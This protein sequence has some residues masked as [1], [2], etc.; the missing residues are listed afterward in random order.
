MPLYEY[1]RL[2]KQIVENA[3]DAII[4]ADRDGIIC[5]WN[6]GAQAMFGY[7]AEEALGQSL[8][9]II[10][11]RLRGR[12]WEGYRKVMSTGITKYDKEL[13]AVPAIRK[14]GKRISLEFSIV[15]LRD[16]G[17]E[18]LGVA[19][20]MRDVTERWQKEKELKERLATAESKTIK[21]T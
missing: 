18:L 1:D 15:P 17:N 7:S 8:D 14:D 6:S 9:L 4:F 19:A 12:H 10:P 5:L 2:C 20:I 13:L 21:E 3:Q 11:E 16:E